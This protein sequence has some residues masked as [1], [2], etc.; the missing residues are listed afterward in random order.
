MVKF[1]DLSI[2]LERFVCTR[3]NRALPGFSRPRIII[4][5]MYVRG[6]KKPYLVDTSRRRAWAR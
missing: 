6:E 1:V 5:T 2:G 4:T 3:E